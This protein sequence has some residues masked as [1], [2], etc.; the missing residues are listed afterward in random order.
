MENIIY[1]KAGLHDIAEI[2]DMRLKFVLEL[3][4]VQPEQKIQT[5]RENMTSYFQKA[6][7]ENSCHTFLAYVD[8]T[9]AGIGSVCYRDMPGN[10]NNITGKWGYIMNMYTLPAYRKRGICNTLL[11]HLVQEGKKDGITAF[12]LHATKEGEQVYKKTNF[13]LHPEPSYRL[14]SDRA[15]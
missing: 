5:L 1:K 12:E 11:N 7:R 2:I 9:I 6:I 10:F 13:R 4:G 15:K 14:Y 8:G 3:S